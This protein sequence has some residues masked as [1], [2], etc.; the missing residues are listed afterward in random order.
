MNKWLKE[1]TDGNTHTSVNNTNWEMNLR[2]SCKYAFPHYQQVKN[3]ERGRERGRRGKERRKGRQNRDGAS[4]I[5][6]THTKKL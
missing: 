5:A 3:E 1:N 6:K 4:G 2:K